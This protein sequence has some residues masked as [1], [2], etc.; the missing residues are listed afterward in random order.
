MTAFFS[1][2]EI[3]ENQSDFYKESYANTIVYWKCPHPPIRPQLACCQAAHL[4]AHS[5]TR[6]PT[7][8]PT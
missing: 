6:W 4:P 5:P 8:P 1:K 3:H 2:T 7:Y